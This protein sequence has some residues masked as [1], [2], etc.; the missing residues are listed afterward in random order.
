MGATVLDL[1]AVLLTLGGSMLAWVVLCAV[2]AW[3]HR[4]PEGPHGPR[5][6]MD[7]ETGEW[8]RWLEPLHPEPSTG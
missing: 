2:A 4:A 3:C 5:R 1:P 6:N 8:G 7:Y